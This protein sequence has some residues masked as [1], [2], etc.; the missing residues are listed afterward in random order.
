MCG[1]NGLFNLN[2]INDANQ[3]IRVMCETSVHRGP[4]NTGFFVDDLVCLGHNR[5]AI[6]DLDEKS[7]QPFYSEDGNLVMAFNG[8]IYNYLDIKK[9]LGDKTFRTNSDTEVLMKA[10]E[11]WGPECLNKLNGM[12][13]IAIWNQQKQELF[14]A[15]DRL[16]IKPLYIFDNGV[17]FAFSSELRSLL[18]LDFISK[19]LDHD[20][21]V[22]YLRYQTVHAPRTII[23]GVE[24]LLPGHYLIVKEDGIKPYKYW[25]L[26]TAYS[27]KS[28][29]QSKEE[30]KTEIRDLFSKAVQRRLVAD[31]PFGAFLSGGIDS[32]A[33]VAYMSKNSTQK[34]KTFSV[35]FAEEEFSEAKYARM[36]AEKYNTDHTEIKLTPEDFLQE[37]PSA[38]KSMDHPS[39][40]GPNSFIVSKVTKEHGVTMA[41]SGLGGDELFCGYDIFTRSAS[42][43]RKKWLFSFPPVLRK[44]GA[45]ILKKLKPSIASDK[46]YEIVSKDYLEIP[47]FYPVN[48]LIFNDKSIKNLLGKSSI[49]TNAVSAIAQDNIAFGKAGFSVPFLSKVSFM[50]INSYMQNV[51]LRDSDQMSM[52]HALEV[53][54]PFLD[55]E[56]LE[57]VYGIKDEVK[58]PHSPKK[59]LIDSLGDLLPDEVVNRKKM[60]FTL[61]WKEWMKSD[62]KE[63][64]EDQLNVLKDSG[65]FNS[66][67]ID[68]LWS[69]FQNNDPKV[70]WSRVW[71]L[72]VLGHWIHENNIECND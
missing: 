72:C 13:T 40:D 14:V 51:L 32:S 9:Q 49:P 50:E 59:L 8:E 25:D 3:A 11:K 30:I 2:D 63:F 16:G 23:Q 34:V 46:I 55:H 4:D 7:N 10:F 71:S 26:N 53:R 41:H 60:G 1:I 48:R 65:V 66:K 19:K 52:A 17:N 15:R 28:D 35:T 67:S 5:L 45:S 31:V 29:G 18:S 68:E 27:K 33:V 24:M 57:Y 58:Y 69:K 21:L 37:L 43:S 36:I 47:Y 38:L 62:L 70:T 56:L 6:I 54:V 64:C 42:L 39:G 61:P 20:A 44:M 12:F 22:D